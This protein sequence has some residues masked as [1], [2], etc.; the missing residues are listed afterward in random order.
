MNGCAD[1]CLHKYTRSD[2][3][4]EKK[5]TSRTCMARLKVM[6]SNRPLPCSG[7]RRSSSMYARAWS[8]RP[9]TP[10]AWLFACVWMGGVGRGERERER[11]C[12]CKRERTRSV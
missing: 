10:Q 4:L 7:D 5:A 2:T 11:R 6:A 3:H 12:V 1:V 9:Q 8:T